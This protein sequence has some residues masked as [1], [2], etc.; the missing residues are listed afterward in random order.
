LS[1]KDNGVG[2]ETSCL[3]NSSDQ[4]IAL[5]LRGMEERAL[6]VAGRL[7]I[8]STQSLGTEIRASFPIFQAGNG[9]EFPFKLPGSEP[10][11]S[12]QL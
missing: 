2:I 4:P 10:E 7:D 1:V 9:N 11:L 5:G 6:A 12:G 3:Q 8:L